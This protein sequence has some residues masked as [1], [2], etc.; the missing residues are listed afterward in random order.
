MVEESFGHQLKYKLLILRH[1]FFHAE[2]AL[3]GSIIIKKY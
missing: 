3:H 1:F 2:N